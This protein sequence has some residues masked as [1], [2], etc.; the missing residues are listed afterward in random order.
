MSKVLITGS[1]GQL[2]SELREIT[3]NY[4]YDFFF[5]DRDTLDITDKQSIKKFVE[6]NNIDTIINCAAYTA[7]DKAE[8]EKDI[9]DAINNQ[10]IKYLAQISKEKNIKLIHIS[11]DYVFDGKSYRPYIETDTTNPNSIYGKS[12]LQGEKALQEINPKTQLS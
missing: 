9:A 1:N 4:S 7:V 8:S 12:K 5:T 6:L 11:T 10:A 3:S 2:G